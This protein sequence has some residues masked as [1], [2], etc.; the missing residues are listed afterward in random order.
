MM[1]S[2]E[3]TDTF[4]PH[5]FSRT[6]SRSNTSSDALSTTRTQETKH[7]TGCTRSIGS[8]VSHGG[9][10]GHPLTKL[11]IKLGSH[12]RQRRRLRAPDRF[13]PTPKV[14]TLNKKN[15]KENSYHESLSCLELRAAMGGTKKCGLD[16]LCAKLDDNPLLHER[17]DDRP[18]PSRRKPSS[19]AAPASSSSS[20]SQEAHPTLTSSC[21]TPDKNFGKG[22]LVAERSEALEVGIGLL[23]SSPDNR[24]KKLDNTSPRIR[25]HLSAM[26]GKDLSP[27][28]TPH[29]TGASLS[30]FHHFSSQSS[31]QKPGMTP[32]F[33]VQKVPEPSPP[34]NE[35]PP[36]LLVSEY[37]SSSLIHG[38]PRPGLGRVPSSSAEGRNSTR[39]LS[40]YSPS[41]LSRPLSGIQ[42]A[43]FMRAIQL[44]NAIVE[45]QR[46]AAQASQ[47]RCSESGWTTKWVHS[48]TSL[49]S[50]RFRKE[51]EMTKLSKG[52]RLLFARGSSS[53]VPSPS[54]ISETH[55]LG[56]N[57]SPLQE[58][59]ETNRTVH[60]TKSQPRLNSGVVPPHIKKNG[61]SQAVFPLQPVWL[62]TDGAETLILI[63]FNGSDEHQNYRVSLPNYL[64]Q[65]ASAK[66]RKDKARD[67][68][69]VV[70]D[71]DKRNDG[72]SER[73]N[74]RDI[75]L[76]RRKNTEKNCGR[77]SITSSSHDSH[78]N[79]AAS[80][81]WLTLN[82]ENLIATSSSGC[83]RI[84][85]GSS[86]V[87]SLHLFSPSLSSS[88]SFCCSCSSFPHSQRLSKGD[89]HNTPPHSS[90]RVLGPASRVPSP[91]LSNPPSPYLTGLPSPSLGM[92]SE[93]DLGLASVKHHLKDL[94]LPF[95]KP[96]A[97]V[98]CMKGCI[99]VS[100]ILEE[101]CNGYLPLFLEGAYP[102][103]IILEGR[104]CV[105]TA[106]SSPGNAVGEASLFS[107]LW[108]TG[109]CSIPVEE[110][111]AALNSD[112]WNK[113][114]PSG[115]QIGWEAEKK[116]ALGE[117]V[118]PTSVLTDIEEVTMRHFPPYLPLPRS[119]SLQG[120][121][122][123]GREEDWIHTAT[124]TT[125]LQAR[126]SS[127]AATSAR[128]GTGGAG[129]SQAFSHQGSRNSFACRHRTLI[130]ATNGH[131]DSNDSEG[132]ETA[133]HRISSRAS[134]F[135]CFR[136]AGKRL[137]G[138]IGEAEA[139]EKMK[140]S[141]AASVSPGCSS[142]CRPEPS[143]K[144]TPPTSFYGKVDDDSERIS[145]GYSTATST[146]N[147]TL[148]SSSSPSASPPFPL[149]VP[150]HPSFSTL[151]LCALPI[152]PSSTLSSLVEERGDLKV[153]E[154]KFKISQQ[155]C[156][157]TLSYPQLP[158]V[159]GSS[160]VGK[161]ATPREDL[162]HVGILVAT[163]PLLKTLWDA[164]I[165]GTEK[166]PEQQSSLKGMK[167]VRH[168]TAPTLCTTVLIYTPFGKIYL[169]RLL[170]SV[171]NW[172]SP[173]QSTSS[174]SSKESPS[175]TSTISSFMPPPPPALL[176]TPMVRIEDCHHSLLRSAFGRAM[177][178]KE[179]QVHFVISPGSPILDDQ[180]ILRTSQAVLRMV[181][182]RQS[183]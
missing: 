5:S 143:S 44:I 29:S 177:R 75:T 142:S 167:I 48:V 154:G 110:K 180:T 25:S 53:N 117:L 162:T 115:E 168:T 121:G 60:M 36:S 124:T 169:E 113:L 66:N 96:Q 108:E 69:C 41:H 14:A 179:G 32:L 18:S 153:G 100:E 116:W 4:L 131:H 119:S 20:V 91:Y 129:L 133:N 6:P 79:P 7:S 77:G 161:H 163:G 38:T 13:G 47:G 57:T 170:P 95:A 70:Q 81:T 58:G 111:E 151:S 71:V 3:A 31:L 73:R 138:S 90:W 182:V 107:P 63:D 1:N 156:R 94:D 93:R 17:C 150:A 85:V 68:S 26:N 34:S 42:P 27:S 120:N 9:K 61:A 181:R 2:V 160:R 146:F 127:A 35:S 78:E 158:S 172:E 16:F 98:V 87:T 52:D 72:A 183:I 145:S 128:A 40:S 86:E 45:N 28:T 136:G 83:C 24:G 103:G 166:L 88:P 144:G 112:M 51:E 118:I 106:L 37:P 97:L 175:H 11:P 43:Q 147:S 80:I 89:S 54:P 104:W 99:L 102:S 130:A 114:F 109:N 164:Y 22:K 65:I 174:A 49:D 125:T 10:D 55:E 155:R 122:K 148:N 126:S 74:R 152:R 33:P 165:Q 157:L 56:M 123:S 134:F 140:R 176:E 135:S 171:D 19:E 23:S 8:E 15:I 149:A 46:T 101:L 64:E 141:F 62:I 67:S 39:C 76:S 50:R 92:K 173:P 12:H 137:G 21:T 178:L 105:G 59:L 139:R 82:M 30:S 84:A 159:G 132:N